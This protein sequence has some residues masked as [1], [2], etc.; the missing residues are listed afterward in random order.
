[1]I[2]S[3]SLKLIMINKGFVKLVYLS[4][5]RTLGESRLIGTT[6]GPVAALITVY[7]FPTHLDNVMGKA[8]G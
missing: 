3:N 8:K 6:T 1:M 7:K 2:L 5:L 4:A